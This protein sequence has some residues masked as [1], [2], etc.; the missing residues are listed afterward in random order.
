M[1]SDDNTTPGI[2]YPYATTNDPA[3]VVVDALR[4]THDPEEARLA[5]QDEIEDANLA[6]GL[7]PGGAS[8]PAACKAPCTDDEVRQAWAELF[9]HV[10]PEARQSLERSPARTIQRGPTRLGL[11]GG[12]GGSPSPSGQGSP[13]P[14]GSDNNGDYDSD[15]EFP[16]EA[17]RLMQEVGNVPREILLVLQDFLPPID[18]LLLGWT[19]PT[20]FHCDNFSFYYI[21]AVY[22]KKWQLGTAMG[23]ERLPLLHHAIKCNAPLPLIVQLLD[24]WRDLGLDLDLGWVKNSPRVRQKRDLLIEPIFL[25]AVV[26]RDDVIRELIDR[27]ASTDNLDRWIMTM[28]RMNWAA[29]HLRD[30]NWDAMEG[31]AIELYQA[32]LLRSVY[33]PF[34]PGSSACTRAASWPAG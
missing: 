19:H 23:E 17:E 31:L 5:E 22:Q 3:A 7:R 2:R 25:A 8:S 11:R 33:R 27:G 26:G 1:A 24:T 16:S 10:S 32:G 20:I 4:S 34:S 14:G 9:N 18:E 28:P 6:P 13:S 21:D 15:E 12:S 30:A 29:R